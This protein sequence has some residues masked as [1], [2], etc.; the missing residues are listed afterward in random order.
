MWKRKVVSGDAQIYQIIR[1]ERGTA[2]LSIFEGY[3]K[4]TS[5]KFDSKA[6]AAVA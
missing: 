3:L 6:M 2:C 1:A 4:A 5:L